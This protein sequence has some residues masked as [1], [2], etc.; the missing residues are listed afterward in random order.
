MYCRHCFRK[1]LVGISEDETAENM[2]D[3]AA[4]VRM[5]KEISNVL[6]SGGDAFSEQ[7]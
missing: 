5:H 7:Q 2:E 6:I 4:Y 1:R 3:M